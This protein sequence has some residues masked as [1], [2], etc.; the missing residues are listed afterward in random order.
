MYGKPSLPDL[1]G[2]C[3]VLP[4]IATYNVITKIKGKK[5]KEK[6]QKACLVLPQTAMYNVITK[7]KGKKIKGK[8]IKKQKC[9]NSLTTTAVAQPL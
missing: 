6:N 8:K 7:I 3:L 4:Q 2:A 5:S 1:C 9:F